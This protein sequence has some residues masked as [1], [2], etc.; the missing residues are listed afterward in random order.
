MGSSLSVAVLAGGASR[1]M[2]TDKG[3]TEIEGRPMALWVLDAVLAG[4]EAPP[5][6]VMFVA[7]ASGYDEL[8][9][10]IAGTPVRVLGDLRPGLG[11]LAGIETALAA[12]ST[13]DVFVAACDLPMADSRLARELARHAGGAAVI[14]ATESGSE[15][16]FAI[17]SRRCLPV[18]SALLDEERLEARALRRAIENA[19]I[20]EVH[21]I[22]V[23]SLGLG[24][25][26]DNV[27][28]PDELAQARRIL[29]PDDISDRENSRK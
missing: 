17:Y 12:A 29:G 13:D 2:G 22:R 6:E 26:L 10:S 5:A 1:R 4:L 18:V 23:D 3:L 21:E 15:P 14:P 28:T 7:N 24:A 25:A 19:A 27:N 8:A 11:P 9:D 20:G 16:C